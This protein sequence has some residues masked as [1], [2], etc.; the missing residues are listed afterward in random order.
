MKLKELNTTLE[1]QRTIC[2]KKDGNSITYHNKDMR[3]VE[4]FE[5]RL[6]SLDRSVSAYGYIRVWK[7]LN[8]Q[9]SGFIVQ[10]FLSI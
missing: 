3:L 5:L 6:M 10:R 4:R 8:L 9:S 2:Y 1:N 7:I